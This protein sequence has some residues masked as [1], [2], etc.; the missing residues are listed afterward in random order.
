MKFLGRKRESG[1]S[2]GPVTPVGEGG[3]LDLYLGQFGWRARLTANEQAEP[4]FF[5]GDHQLPRDGGDAAWRALVGAIFEDALRDERRRIGSIRLLIDDSEAI[6]SDHRHEVFATNSKAMIFEFGKEKL[7]SSDICWGSIQLFPGEESASE[8]HV[9]GFVPAD[10]LRLMLGHFERWAT[11]VVKAVPVTAVLAERA[12][13]EGAA[14]CSL[15]FGP[16]H[17][18][19]LLV[20]PARNTIVARL[21]SV[22]MRDVIGA[23]AGVDENTAMRELGERRFLAPDSSAVDEQ[24]PYQRAVGPLLRRIV[25]SARTALD[26]FENQKLADRPAHFTAYGDHGMVKGLLDAVAEGIG[27]PGD[28]SQDDVFTLFTSSDPTRLLNLLSE[29]ERP[30]LSVGKITYAYEKDRFVPAQDVPRPAPSQVQ[31]RGKVG[32]R[33]RLDGTAD[34]NA[35]DGLAAAVHRH[36]PSFWPLLRPF[37]GAAPSA[38]VGAPASIALRSDGGMTKEERKYAIVFVVLGLAVV[39]L[40]VDNW[41]PV[42]GQRAN[43]A[44]MYRQNLTA[45]DVS[46]SKVSS[47][48]QSAKRGSAATAANK[49]LWTEKFLALAETMTDELWMTDIYLEEVKKTIG[50][51]EVSEKRLIMQGA[52]LPST[53]GHILTIA[54]YIGKLR[55]DGSPFMADFRDLQFA[56]ANLDVSDSDE[57]VRFTLEATYDDNKRLSAKRNSAQG[58]GG[59]VGETVDAAQARN[60]AVD[61]SVSLDGQ[62]GK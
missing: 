44:A 40:A 33:A 12:S 13:K 56:G 11:H 3:I 30:L 18:R 25:D 15:F 19:L 5:Q 9:Y 29:A 59:A 61:A 31:P 1:V 2:G 47:G 37:F 28:P 17:T 45:L 46:L 35:A 38:K 51:S 39:Y 8:G 48:P 60:A 43:T 10:H 55:S 57:V 41:A 53:Y 26:F 20:D 34:E 14:T 24:D 62:L 42:K 50:K 6:L 21:C 36:F 16:R 4:R 54:N 32:T 7:N 23:L 58:P 22:G 27:V 49:V 52:A